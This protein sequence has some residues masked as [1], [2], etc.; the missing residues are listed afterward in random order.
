[1][2]YNY[3][4]INNKIK[5]RL[6]ESAI[7]YSGDESNIRKFYTQEISN[8]IT[9]D[10]SREASNYFWAQ[11][12]AGQRV[13]QLH[14][15]IPQL[16][17]EKMV[18]LLIGNGFYYKVVLPDGTVDEKNT[19][20]LENILDENNFDFK[21]QEGIELESA[22]GGFAFKISINPD[23]REPIL[24]IVRP[25]FYE[26]VVKAGRI[27]E[28]I[29][30][31]YYSEGGSEYR[32]REIYGADKDGAYIKYKLQLRNLSKAYSQ[33]SSAYTDVAITTLEA[34]K[35]LE[36]IY[37]P[38]IKRK[39]S[40]YKPNKVP[41][42]EFIGSVL[43]ES[44]YSGSFGAFDAI[45]EI[46]STWIQEF[47]DGKITKMWPENLLPRTETG[48]LTLPP[49]LQK[50]FIVYGTGIDQSA[51][52]TQPFV[53][54]SELQVDKHTQSL[55]KWLTLVI[56]NAGLSPLTLGI[57]GLESIA[58][59]EQSQNAREKTSIRTRNKKLKL[60]NKTLRD[61]FNLLL[62]ADDIKANKTNNLDYKVNIVFEDYDLKTTLDRTEEANIGLTAGS[63]SIRTAVDYIHED[64]SEHEKLLEVIRIKIEKNITIF[65]KEEEIAYREFILN[66]PDSIKDS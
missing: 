47:R 13:R 9:D 27:I 35:H 51:Q 17:P 26:P 55:T 16:I 2:T 65:T 61:L 62:I 54:Q 24:E 21:I 41:N 43:G 45:D 4:K 6:K 20:R 40:L 5:K 22:L 38:N 32:L 3:N 64:L 12:L 33:E 42:S 57:T 52:Q 50:D 14:S 56:N 19:E 44:D 10:L 31:T 34:T 39:L 30:D 53:L 46:L 18:D 36:D 59:N 28:D 7:W 48:K 49:T 66:H 23:F 63:W 11:D 25:D 8:Y 58:A 15:G 60:W 37:F 29:F 1:M